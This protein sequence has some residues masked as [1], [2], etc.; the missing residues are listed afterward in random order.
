MSDIRRKYFH[1]RTASTDP[2]TN[3]QAILTAGLQRNQSLG[4]RIEKAD[5]TGQTRFIILYRE[6][7]DILSG[8]MV[9]FTES[10][11]QPFALIDTSLREA[12]LNQ[13]APPSDDPERRH[14]FVQGTLYFAI[15][16][17]H[18]LLLQSA[19]FR[20]TQFT[21]YVNWIARKG[22]PPDQHLSLIEINEKPDLPDRKSALP[23]L[24][25]LKLKAPMKFKTES[26]LL[27]KENSG[28]RSA[29]SVEIRSGRR[30]MEVLRQ[31]LEFFA[32]LPNEGFEFQEPPKSG[33]MLLQIKTK[34]SK[35]F[36]TSDDLAEAS[37]RMDDDLDLSMVVPGV[38][39]IG[40]D[41][42]RIQESIPVETING[43]PNASAV[44]RIMRSWLPP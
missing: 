18:V 23:D 1:Y 4:D 28:S 41:S 20:S 32:K 15:R 8:V 39:R 42:L 5:S 12:K 34:N 16:M 22:L 26:A 11:D 3:L 10:D 14:Q 19:E 6:K 29:K 38:G 44:F 43:L 31:T 40:L 30:G 13:I 24:P 37:S 25:P 17:N 33:D 7:S 36:K 2:S 9:S 27:K 35:S 21:E